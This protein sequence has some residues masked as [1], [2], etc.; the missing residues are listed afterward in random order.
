MALAIDVVEDW[1]D[2]THRFALT[3]RQLEELD[4]KTGVGPLAM[5]T[6]LLDGGWRLAD[7]RET[8]RLGLIGGGLK[9]VD[10]LVLVRRYVDEAPLEQSAPLAASILM[11]ALRGRKTDGGE[12]NETAARSATDPQGSIS[13][14][15]DA[16][17]A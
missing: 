7:V 11:A 15:S 1:A 3:I 9:P 8:I 16:T 12:G 14:P 10:A 2:G 13:P 5:L 17:P 6:R 4:D